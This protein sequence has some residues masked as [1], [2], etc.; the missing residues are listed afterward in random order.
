MKVLWLV[1]LLLAS[2]SAPAGELS[3]ELHVRK[4]VAT[5]RNVAEVMLVNSGKDDIVVLG[6]GLG[7]SM[8]SM[9]PA[10]AKWELVLSIARTTWNGHEVVRS[11]SEYSPVTLKPG[12]CA[13]YQLLPHPFANP[14]T[15]FRE[16][17]SSLTVIYAISPEQGARHGVWSGR[18]S[19]KTHQIEDGQIQ[20]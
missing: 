20:P 11:T 4:S 19:S 10:G 8:R 2:A 3:V 12:D 13:K 14:F 5:G 6:K 15:R 18:A 1:P 17:A 16:G 9:D 7:Q